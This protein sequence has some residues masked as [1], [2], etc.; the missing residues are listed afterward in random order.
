M[1]VAAAGLLLLALAPPAAAQSGSVMIEDLTWPEVR[2]AIAAGK[3]TA[4]YFAGSTEQN[5]PHL[6]IGKH[7]FIAQHVARKIAEELGNAL[8]YPVMP[9]ALTGDP[10]KK[11]EHMRFPGS[12]S[13][14]PETFG[15][16]AREVTASAISAGFRNVFLM[17]D[18]GGGQDVLKK[19][20]G[21]LDVQWAPQGVRVRYV[22]DLYYK[23]EEQARQYLAQRG[24]TAGAHAGGPDTAQVMF[25]D[26]DRKWI[27]R[28][29][30]APGDKVNGVDGDPRQAS[31]EFGKVFIQFKVDSA[32]AQIRSMLAGKE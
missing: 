1:R 13:L 19:V 20:A 28:D 3:T 25:L 4:I 12:V 9:F 27:R 18:H 2:S 21:E 32:V 24:M 11:T 5:G 22:P 31:A 6:A 8:V 16:V 7:N 26:K 30:L 17:G 14:S 15:A 29:K 10:A 23:S